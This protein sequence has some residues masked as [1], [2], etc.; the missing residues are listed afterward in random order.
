MPIFL[1]DVSRSISVNSDQHAETFI[2][3][4]YSAL[5]AFWPKPKRSMIFCSPL[6]IPTSDAAVG[7]HRERRASDI[8]VRQ[9]VC[10]LG[11]LRKKK[12]KSTTFG[13][14]IPWPATLRALF[15]VEGG[16]HLQGS[17][18][19]ASARKEALQGWV[20]A[21]PWGHLRFGDGVFVTA[22]SLRARGP[23]RFLSRA[24]P[25]CSQVWH[26]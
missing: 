4:P 25:V 13:E 11:V 6:I 22:Q 10:D 2:I 20:E 26:P 8:I 17:P 18:R 24:G 12:K 1:K 9:R 7:G 5:H 19:G 14:D 21:R 15:G 23:T 3:S 16:S